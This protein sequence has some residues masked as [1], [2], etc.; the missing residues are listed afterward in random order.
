V[1]IPLKKFFESICPCGDKRDD[2]GNKFNGESRGG[3]TLCSYTYYMEKR[4]KNYHQ[5]VFLVDTPPPQAIR[6]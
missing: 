4:Q 3:R 6:V 5:P 2:D 1:F